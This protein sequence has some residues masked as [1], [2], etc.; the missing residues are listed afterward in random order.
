L[1]F[2]LNLSVFNRF[3][4]EIYSI[5]DAIKNRRQANLPVVGIYYA[6]YFIPKSPAKLPLQLPNQ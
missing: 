5:F 1:I 2:L 6:N 4:E 3:F